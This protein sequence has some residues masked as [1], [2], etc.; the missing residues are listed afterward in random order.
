MIII[1]P[2]PKYT[3][4]QITE[5]GLNIVRRGGISKLTA[6]NLGEELNC[7]S[8]PIFTEFK[9]MEEVRNAVYSEAKNLYHTYVLNKGADSNA[10]RRIDYIRFAKSEPKLFPMMFIK[11]NETEYSIAD[12]LSVVFTNT[13]SLLV[14]V[15]KDYNLTRTDAYTLCSSMWLFIHGIACTCACG[16]T[17]FIE[18]EVKK[19]VDTTFEAILQNLRK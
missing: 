15:Q 16:M 4:E 8:Q 14:S 11:E 10:F 9:N 1:P 3:R 2:K 7:S 12:I 18:P 5:A 13:D 17:L 6:R 19:L